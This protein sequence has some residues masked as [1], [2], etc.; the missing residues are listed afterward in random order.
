MGSRLLLLGEKQV[1]QDITAGVA[2]YD[3]CLQPFICFA[4]R[5]NLTL[6]AGFGTNEGLPDAISLHVDLP[7]VSA[8]NASFFLSDIKT[9]F[10]LSPAPFRGKIKGRSGGV[11]VALSGSLFCGG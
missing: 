6:L 2:S 11:F 5:L 9:P 10:I 1:K 4:L 7:P 3:L 8:L